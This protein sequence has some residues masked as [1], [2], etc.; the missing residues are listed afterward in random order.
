VG[1][2]DGGSPFC[3]IDRVGYVLCAVSVL[4]DVPGR[5]GRRRWQ[6]ML[7]VIAAMRR[8][9][10]GREALSSAKHLTVISIRMTKTCAL[11]KGMKRREE[12]P[13]MGK[14]KRRPSQAVRAPGLSGRGRGCKRLTVLN[15]SLTATDFG[16]GHNRCADQ[17]RLS[18]IVHVMRAPILCQR[19]GTF[20]DLFRLIV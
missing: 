5:M 14:K 4:T 16:V 19:F 15:L 13:G 1:A 2:V 8:K 10:R 18:L 3:G 6:G 9:R 7:A 12:G 11:I 20:S 17:Q